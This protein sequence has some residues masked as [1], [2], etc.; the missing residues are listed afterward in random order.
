MQTYL[1]NRLLLPFV[2][3]KKVTDGFKEDPNLIGAHAM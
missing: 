1:T 2:T 3:V